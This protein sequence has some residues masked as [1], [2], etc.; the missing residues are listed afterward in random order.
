[1]FYISTYMFT[2]LPIH[3]YISTV[4]LPPA[5]V[6]LFIFNIFLYCLHLACEL[7]SALRRFV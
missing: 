3:N 1:M 6:L 4:S 5:A 2:Q 7:L